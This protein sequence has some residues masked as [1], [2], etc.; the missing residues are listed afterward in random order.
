MKLN[1]HKIKKLSKDKGL[2]LNKL[3]ES[4]NVSRTAYYSLSR[5]ESLLPSSVHAI[6][7]ALGTSSK[8]ILHDSN[9][10]LA[11]IRIMQRKLE[12]ILKKRPKIT[13]RENAWHTLLLLEELPIERLRRALRRGRRINI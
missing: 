4:A 8:E 12:R 13:S 11:R 7:N 2:S 6:A 10:E 9:P 3:L 5:K 1:I